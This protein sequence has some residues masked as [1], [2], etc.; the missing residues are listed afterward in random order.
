MRRAADRQIGQRLTVALGFLC[1]MVLPFLAAARDAV[2]NVP[3]EVTACGDDIPP[4]V[5][6]RLAVEV[7]ILWRESSNPPEMA[8]LRVNIRCEGDVARIEVGA[9]AEISRS[10]VDL[11]GLDRE[12]RARLLALKATELIHLVGEKTWERSTAAKGDAGAASTTPADDAGKSARGD[13]QPTSGSTP[14]PDSDASASP[15]E[16]T[17]APATADQ[18]SEGKGLRAR[19]GHSSVS[20]GAFTLF[21]GRPFAY[22][23]GPSLAGTLSLLP[24]MSLGA[25]VDG[26]FG[27]LHGAD[28]T[29][30]MRGVAGSATLLFVGN[31]GRLAWA[32]GAGGRLGLLQLSGEVGQ[33]APIVGKTASGVWAGPLIATTLS[34]PLASRWFIEVGA[35]GGIVTLPLGAL[36]DQGQ[37]FYT[38][39]GPWLGLRASLGFDLARK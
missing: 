11:T 9:T 30:H 29:L 35:E 26:T 33:S 38:L 5:R 37:R 22:V 16:A 19:G 27:A 20:A 21:G 17:G 3:V 18:S 23:V 1:V 25:E 6:E 24:R 28:R 32:I 34:Y 39:D 31:A 7:E 2:P 8:S 14:Q 10:A 12:A 4:A 36:I 13:Q 15:L